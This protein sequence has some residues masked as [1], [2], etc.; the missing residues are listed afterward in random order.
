MLHTYCSLSPSLSPPPSLS[1]FLYSLLLSLSPS[2]PISLSTP[3]L[4]P[5]LPPPLSFLSSPQFPEWLL[6]VQPT[7]R[8]VLHL[9]PER[10]EGIVQL[11]SQLS[12]RLFCHQVITVVH[13][14]CSAKICHDLSHLHVGENVEILSQFVN[15]GHNTKDGVIILPPCRTVYLCAFSFQ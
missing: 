11:S 1:L 12:L 8:Q 6:E 9:L 10:V 3:S 5:S 7:L 2:L 14:L 15:N 13:V 4:L